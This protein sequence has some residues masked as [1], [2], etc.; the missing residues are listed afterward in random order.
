MTCPMAQ[1]LGVYALGSADAAERRLVETHLPGCAQCREELASLAPL[2]VLLARVPRDLVPSSELDA[3]AAARTDHADVPE[4]VSRTRRPVR[5][6]RT[7]TAVAVAAASAGL[8]GGF[9][10]LP[11]G[12]AAVPADVTLSAA[13]PATH[14]QATAQLT[15]TSWGTSIRVQADGL[16]LNEQCWLVVRSRDGSTEIA[17]YWEAWRTGPV[18]VPASAAWRVSDI[19]DVQVVTKG[20]TLVDL[21]AAPAQNRNEGHAP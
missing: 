21:P 12:A 4:I 9:W 6:W 7:V 10:L 3:N 5:A 1:Y 14:V 13:D 15:G 19:A 8:G 17:G 16:P 11:R 2:P 20:G 18:T